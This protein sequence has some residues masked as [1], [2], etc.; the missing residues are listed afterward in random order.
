MRAQT[1]QLLVLVLWAAA[2][3]CGRR[4][5]PARQGGPLT[6]SAERAIVPPLGTTRIQVSGGTG[7]I[8]LFTLPGDLQSGPRAK[9]DAAGRS[10]TAG[11]QGSVTDVVR[12]RD[13][14]GAERQVHIAVGTALSVSPLE[15]SVGPNDATVLTVTGGQ[16]PYCF[17]LIGDAYC[18]LRPAG[19][20]C[21]AAATSC[22]AAAADGGAAD[23][24][25]DGTGRFVA[26]SCGPTTQ[27]IQISDFN[28]AMV[29]ARVNV[30]ASLR[31]VA[32]QTAVRP[33]E[34]AQLLPSGGVPPYSFRMASHGNESFG[35]VDL[36]GRYTA[37]PNADERDTIVV[38]DFHGVETRISIDVGDPSVRLPSRESYF[39]YHGDLNGDG[40]QDLI[41]ASQGSI[42]AGLTISYGSPLGGLSPPIYLAFHDQILGVLVTDLDGDGN[43]DIVVSVSPRNV[44]A[45]GLV[46]LRLIR[47]QSNG[48]LVFSPDFNF[49]S[50]GNEPLYG[51]PDVLDFRGTGGPAVV[52][53]IGGP[54]FV[55]GPHTLLLLGAP[56]G[57]LQ[58]VASL[59]IGTGTSVV[60]TDGLNARVV[61][62][63]G[64]EAVVVRYFGPGYG[65]GPECPNLAVAGIALEHLGLAFDGGFTVN[66]A[67]VSCLS[68]PDEPNIIRT[69]VLDLNGD[70]RADFYL[71]GYDWASDTT[72]VDLLR[73]AADGG[74]QS[75]ER[76]TRPTYLFD[77]VGHMLGGDELDL[78]G[79]GPGV[80]FVD[81]DGGLQALDQGFAAGTSAVTSGD[82][83]GDHIPD[84]ATID[85]HFMLTVLPGT[86]GG[87][88]GAGRSFHFGRGP[89]LLATADLDGDGKDDLFAAELASRFFAGTRGG[90]LSLEGSD[91]LQPRAAIGLQGHLIVGW[92]AADGGQLAATIQASDAGSQSVALSVPSLHSLSVLD[93]SGIR[94]QGKL[95]AVGF[96]EQNFRVVPQTLTLDADGGLRT[97]AAGPSLSGFIAVPIEFSG[98]AHP[99]LAV[100]DLAP[101]STSVS[102]Y[103]AAGASWGTQPTIVVA[104]TAALLGIPAYR[105]ASFSLHP[106]G[107]RDQLLLVGA[108]GSGQGCTYIAELA[109]FSVVAGVLVPSA[110]TPQFV[111]TCG[112]PGLRVASADFD[113]DGNTDLLVNDG[114][115]VFVLR[116]DGTGRFVLEPIPIGT[117]SKAITVGDFDGDGWTDIA[118]SR[119]D[120][121]LIQIGLNAH[122]G[123]FY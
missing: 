81:V 47:G 44:S 110:T 48:S 6:A 71:A 19:K 113:H 9:V 57:G 16:A 7:E 120:L 43:D 63:G 60:S 114:T 122:D 53:T 72:M 80:R 21:S 38:T 56:D 23:S 11:A 30:G 73:S 86:L 103:P 28:G 37:G 13:G 109:S 8:T 123:G 65:F 41:A 62:G 93:P 58:P 10:Y 98:S 91:P 84:F 55:T 106:G 88:T 69:G 87:R 36:T 94:L 14:A 5:E 31:V 92:T 24:C 115:Q 119:A 26:G 97:D 3:A 12:V 52:G 59:P 89:Y 22:Q 74:W 40:L 20:I 45:A 111:N 77:V 112:F 61:D 102:L 50:T 51:N 33:L 25:V 15:T 42:N 104:D 121:P 79:S 49:P 90:R 95:L 85:D 64:V 66:T 82:F 27:L 117:P 1:R 70:D 75:P 18:P 32:S 39:L 68:L 78:V 107:P 35:S 34:S 76:V 101:G 46:A 116:G 67:P 108:F 100:L 2:C 17:E 118:W 99:D 54:S 4:F 105:L 29:T 83:D 96:D